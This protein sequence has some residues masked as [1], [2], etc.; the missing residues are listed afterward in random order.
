M[1][2]ARFMCFI[3]EILQTAPRALPAEFAI[4]NA[5]GQNISFVLRPSYTLHTGGFWR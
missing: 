4:A 5:N 2:E 3:T 1:K